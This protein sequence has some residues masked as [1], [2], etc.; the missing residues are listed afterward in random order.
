MWDEKE[1]SWK[2]IENFYNI[3]SQQQFRLAR[4]LTTTH[5]HPQR[6]SIMKVKFARQILVLWLP[7]AFL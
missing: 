3:D 6:L 7:Q 2:H 5:I 1:T 4:K